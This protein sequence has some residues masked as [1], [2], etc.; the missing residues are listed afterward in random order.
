MK[1][2][3][4]ICLEEMHE[5]SYWVALRSCGH[6][7]DR[8]CID[9]ALRGFRSRCPVCATAAVETFN[10]APAVPW[11]KLYPSKG[12]RD[13]SDEQVK[14]KNDLDEANQKLASLQSKLTRTEDTLD[15]SRQEHGNTLS[16]LERTLSTINQLNQDNEQLKKSN[17]DYLSSIEKLKTSYQIIA[18]SSTSSSSLNEAPGEQQ[19]SLQ[20]LLKVGK[21]V[22][23]AASLDSINSLANQALQRDYLDLKAKYQDMANREQL[24]G[25]KVA[26]LTAQL[27]RSQTAENSQDRERLQKQLFGALIEKSVLSNAVTNLNLEKQRLLDE[28]RVIQEKWNAMLPDHK[29]LQ[30]AETAWITNNLYLQE[31]LKASNE[32][33]VKMKALNHDYATEILGLKEEVRALRETNTK[34]DAEKFQIINNVKRYEA[35][36]K[37][38]EERIEVLSDGKGQ[39]MEEL[40]VAQQPWQLFL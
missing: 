32:D 31:L 29:K 23:D 26:D 3:C 30:D 2:V 1:V 35:E 18:N 33:L 27:Q 20:D 17:N 13:E 22:L 16:T 19:F 39:M 37:Q 7:F 14:M 34:H 4:S 36:I 12:D 40:I 21:T 15:S 5:D 11:I 25:V 10:R 28:K 38:R 8:T 9:S 24:T 6:V